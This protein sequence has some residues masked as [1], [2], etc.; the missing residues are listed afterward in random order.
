M[1]KL[2][3]MCL[4]GDKFQAERVHNPPGNLVLEGRDI[5]HVVLEPFAPQLSA[6]AAV[7]EPGV[8]ADLIARASDATLEEVSDAQNIGNGPFIAGSLLKSDGGVARNDEATSNPRQ[9]RRDVVG[10]PIGKIILVGFTAEIAEGQNDNRK[11]RGF[12]LCFSSHALRHRCRDRRWTFAAL[13]DIRPC[14]KPN[15]ACRAGKPGCGQ[16]G[17]QPPPSR[18]KLGRSWRDP[19]KTST[20]ALDGPSNISNALLSHVFK[21]QRQAIAN[22]VTHRARQANSADVSEDLQPCGDVDAVAQ[23]IAVLGDYIAQIDPNP[24][25][26]AAILRDCGLA[27]GYADLDLDGTPDSLDGTSELNKQPVAHRLDDPP[28]VL[29]NFRIDESP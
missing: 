19:I 17:Y 10:Q 21:F 9:V 3:P 28:S 25:P 7:N 6:G 13:H 22:L 5:A 29:R 15:D 8:D 18:M 14:R 26:N 4:C 1:G 23:D 12:L 11:P 20:V 16:A 2:R 24:E 27:R